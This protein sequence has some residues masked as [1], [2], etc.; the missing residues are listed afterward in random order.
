MPAPPPILAWSMRAVL[1]AAFLPLLADCG[2]KSNQFAPPCPRPAFL[3]PAATIDQYRPGATAGR[4][5]LTDLIVHGRIVGLSG[6]CQAGDKKGQLATTIVM[7][8]ELTRGP[9]MQGRETD[10]PA[11]LAVTEGDTILDK[12]IY[13]IHVAFPSNVDRLMLNSDNLNL[14]LPVTPT[15]S[16]AAYTILAGFQL[17]P[18]QL[19]QSRSNTTP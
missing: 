9:A 13:P 18:D 7:T 3:G 11:F 6:S 14:I 1:L 2:P 4:H 10:V 16:G 17:T 12:R 19:E 15:K 5:D 8:V